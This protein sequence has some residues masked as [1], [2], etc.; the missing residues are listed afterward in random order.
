MVRGGEGSSDL[1]GRQIG[2]AGKSKNPVEVGVFGRPFSESGTSQAA[3]FSVP[4]SNR[5]VVGCFSFWE[6]RPEGRP[7]SQMTDGSA[8]LRLSIP[9]GRGRSA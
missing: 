5:I 6:M 2:E 8:G 9:T 1:L 7:P 3:I 4:P